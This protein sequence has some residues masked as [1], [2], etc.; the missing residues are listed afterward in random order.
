MGFTGDPYYEQLFLPYATG[1]DSIFHFTPQETLAQ[2]R[3][4]E[5]SLERELEALDESQGASS[6]ILNTFRFVI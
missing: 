5:S 6:Q 1:S 3:A 4:T 2:L